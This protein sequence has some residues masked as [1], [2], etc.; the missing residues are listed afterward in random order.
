[1]KDGSYKCTNGGCNKL[2]KDEDG[3]CEHH[4]GQPVFHDIK[5]YWSCCKDKVTWDWDEFI[6]IPTCKKGKHV[7]KMI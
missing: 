6:K 1:M 2:Y 4:E 5:K 7:P 3:E